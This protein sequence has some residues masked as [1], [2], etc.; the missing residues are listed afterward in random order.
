[1][2]MPQLTIEDLVVEYRT[3]DYPVRPIDH[4]DLTVDAGSLVLLLGPSGCGKTTLLSALGG[5]LTVT[6]GTIRFGE[7]EITALS[8]PALTAYRRDQVGFVFQ[9]FNLVPSLSAFENVMVPLRTAR[10]P[11]HERQRRADSL[12]ELVG[13]TDRAHHKPGDLSGGQQQRVAI[14]RAL[15]LEPSLVLADEPTAHLDFVQVEEVL[16]LIRSLASAG[17]TVVVSTHDE[18]M[19]PLADQVVEMVPKFR[20]DHREPERVSLA[21]GDTLFHQGEPSDLVYLVESGEIDIL[22]VH[23]DGSEELLTTVGPGNYFGEIG[24][25]LGLAR[26]A[27]ARARIDAVVIGLTVRAF[28]ERVG[29]DAARGLIGL[30]PM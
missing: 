11:R 23:V 27:T 18:R 24:P 25:M 3:G 21:A 14:A 2:L 20:N 8:R 19:V 12:L 28:R 13:L 7:V 6:S 10:V 22:R 30:D 9:A 1:M 5:I 15:A 17:R 26:S 29:P 16:K 4:L